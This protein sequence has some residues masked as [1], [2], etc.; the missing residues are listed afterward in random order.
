[1]KKK[2]AC[3]TKRIGLANRNMNADVA[4]IV[5]AAMMGLLM[6]LHPENR[7]R[8]VT[9]AMIC[10]LAVMVLIHNKYVR[11]VI[12]ALAFL[13]LYLSDSGILAKLLGG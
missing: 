13:L 8:V 11:A 1:V 3:I 4:A 10:L 5:V 9:T 7:L 2:A 12:G 6:I